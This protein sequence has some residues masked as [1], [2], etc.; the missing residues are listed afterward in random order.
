[1]P[2]RAAVRIGDQQLHLTPTEY[3]LLTVLASD[4]ESVF[5]RQ[6]I[7]KRVWGYDDLTA[8]HLVDVHVGRLRAKLN[9]VPTELPY[10]VTVRGRGFRLVAHGEEGRVRAAEHGRA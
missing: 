2:R 8:N 7:S 1:M 6:S 10:L 3:R 9:S 4:P 5:D